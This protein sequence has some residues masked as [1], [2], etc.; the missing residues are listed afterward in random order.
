MNLDIFLDSLKPLDLIL[1]QCTSQFAQIIQAGS[2]VVKGDGS[3]AHCGLII[4]TNICPSLDVGETTDK[5]ILESTCT[6]FD[7]TVDAET[8]ELVFGTTVRRADLVLQEFLENGYGVAKCSLKN[9]PFLKGDEKEKEK[10]KQVM[11]NIHKNYLVKKSLYELNIFS[12]IGALFPSVSPI[13]DNVEKLTNFVTKK[14]PWLFCSEFICIIYRDIGVLDKNIDVEKYVPADFSTLERVNLV[15]SI[16]H[17]PPIFLKKINTKST[18]WELVFK[19]FS[20]KINKLK[21]SVRNS[22]DS[23]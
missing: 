18:F 6:Y 19:I 13:R 22:E 15:N 17:L 9:N 1:V 3:F 7:K 4:D 8:Q 12:L 10:I 16:M 11:I 2:K 14:H 20:K 21:R 23:D 5:F